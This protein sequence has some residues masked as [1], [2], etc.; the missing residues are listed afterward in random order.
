M[1]AIENLEVSYQGVIAAVRGFSLEAPDR[2]V[3]ALL[4]ANGAGKTTILRAIS[5][6]L[7]SQGGRMTHG[8][9]E[10]DGRPITALDATRSCGWV[11]PRCWRGVGSSR[12]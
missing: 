12:S 3:V 10:F 4:G 8:S 7:P 11:S 9:V 1:L 6:L 5:G 2:G